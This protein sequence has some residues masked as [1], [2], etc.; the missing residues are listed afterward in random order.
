[1]NCIITVL[2]IKLAEIPGGHDNVNT[3]TSSSVCRIPHSSLP[4][5][6]ILY[7]C[8]QEEGRATGHENTMGTVVW[9]FRSRK[10][11]IEFH[12]ALDR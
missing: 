11:K 8:L 6:T 9:T 2:G 3:M 5:S 10:L 1:M 12:H 4:P 7:L